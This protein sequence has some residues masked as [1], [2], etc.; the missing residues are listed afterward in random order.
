MLTIERN[1]NLKGLTRVYSQVPF[2][3]ADG[4]NLCMEII[5]PQNITTNQNDGLP[6]IVFV[7]GSAWTSPDPF[8]E[9]TQFNRFAVAGFVVAMLRHRNIYEGSPAPAFLKDVKCGIRYMRQNAEQY[10]IDPKRVYILGTSSGGNAALLA[11]LTP[12]DPK[13]KTD[14]YPNQSDSVS[15]VAECF[16]PTDLNLFIEQNPSFTELLGVFCGGKVNHELLSEM[17]PI[18]YI[19]PDRTNIPFLIL[20]GDGDSCV[21]F[22]Q[23][24][25]L[26]RKLEACDADVQF[27]C[28]KDAEHESDF[29]SEEVLNI[30]LNFYKKQAFSTK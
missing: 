3:N 23:S 7:Q 28:V 14:E 8:Y 29:W 19:S 18:N 9:L 17:S 16:G 27:V 12:D 15:A 4:T 24:E 26:V 22:S 13:Y 5:T 11:A 2:S 10:G 25:K 21:P 1:P 30:I 6:L 20:H